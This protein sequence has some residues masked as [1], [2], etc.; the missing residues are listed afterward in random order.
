MGLTSHDALGVSDAHLLICAPPTF[1]RALTRSHPSTAERG[2][3]T[4]HAT[5]SAWKPAHGAM[6]LPSKLHFLCAAKPL[7]SVYFELPSFLSP[8]SAFTVVSG[9]SKHSDSTTTIKLSSGHSWYQ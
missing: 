3:Y 8:P 2:T 5:S 4:P 9:F 7:A 1:S 6:S